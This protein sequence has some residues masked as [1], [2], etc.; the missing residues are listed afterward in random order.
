MSNGSPY[1]RRATK[2]DSAALSRICLLTADAGQSAEKLH[3]IQELP[4]LVY[5]LPYV[6]VPHTAGFVLVD[7]LSG[8]EAVVGYILL[9]L[10]S[11]K[12]EAAAETQW[13]PPLRGK[14][15]KP[16]ENANAYSTPL[17]DM[18]RYYIGLLHAPNTAPDACVA[19]SPA[20]MHIDVLPAYQRR[21]WGRRL[22]GTA[23]K[24]LREDA[25]LKGLW[26]GMDPRNADAAKFYAKLGF[27]NV[28]GGPEN[29]VCL[30][31]ADW[32]FD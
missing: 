29:N 25:G 5:A 7:N 1:I 17:T 28:E 13:Y 27:K 9:A 4:G 12:F 14:Y 15:P 30:S 31:V 21:G 3:T 11:R 2:E 20:H 16:D 10:D 8:D 23:L 32:K 24:Y 26:L 18:D 6:H 19:F 22:V